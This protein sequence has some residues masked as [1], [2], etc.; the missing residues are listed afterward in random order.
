MTVRIPIQADG[1]QVAKAFTDI[2]KA[3]E[4]AGQAGRELSKIDLSHPE[5]KEQ[6]ED[7][8]NYFVN[9]DYVVHSA[10]SK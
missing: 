8:R 5:L 3:M 6:A 10:S 9:S 4:R 1:G 7:I 2:R